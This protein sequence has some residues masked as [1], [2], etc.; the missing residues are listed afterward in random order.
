MEL[1]DRP[2]RHRRRRVIATALAS[3]LLAVS[4]LLGCSGGSSTGPDESATPTTTVSAETTP[5]AVAATAAPSTT[6]ANALRVTPLAADFTGPADI[7]TASVPTISAYAQRPAAPD[8][9][10]ASWTFPSVTPFGNPMTFLV[11]SAIGD[12][13][14]VQLPMRP[15]G[16]A[17]WLHRSEV[18]I[19]ATAKRIVIDRQRRSVEVFDGATQL[20]RSSAVV[21][22]PSTPTPT[23]TYFV[24]D[25]L[26]TD[27]PAGVY[28]PYIIALSA[29]SESFEF[30]NGQEPLV[31]L[32]GTNEPELIGTAAS[33]GCIRL[34]ND[35]ATKLVGLLPLGTPVYVV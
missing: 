13:V 34:P 28:G 16:T 8:P 25:L 4:G 11:T 9:T 21:G 24:T 31:A 18:T 23:G 14:E 32:H 30:W 35:V 6:A 10:Q 12:W 20:A 19:A 27:D 1:T 22:K 15:N 3:C 17:G 2:T 33:N 26:Q 29:R 5:T 7:A